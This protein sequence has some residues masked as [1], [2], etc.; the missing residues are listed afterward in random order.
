[1]ILRSSS[2]APPQQLAPAP[3]ARH[4]ALP[5]GM[6]DLA[7][8]VIVG[9]RRNLAP[10]ELVRRGMAG[11][12]D[13]TEILDKLTGG[14]VTEFSD[15]LDRLEFWLEVSV[16]ASLFAGAAALIALRRK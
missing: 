16:A 2:S 3:A 6:G 10:G 15:Q 14:K 9:A 13:A 4:R 12:G 1:M 11:I 5:G 8:A 7:P